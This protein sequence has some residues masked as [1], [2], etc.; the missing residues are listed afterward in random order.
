MKKSIVLILL[1]LVSTFT[2][3]AQSDELNEIV[4]KGVELHDNGQYEKAIETYK[5]ALKIDKKSIL[6]HY[7]MATTYFTL[8]KYDDAIK[9][10]DKV[11]KQKKKYIGSAYIIKGSAL[12][13][14][15]KSKAAIKAYRKGIKKDPTNHLLHYNLGLAA[16]NSKD[17]K[18]AEE[19]AIGAIQNKP[20]HGS[21]HIL[22]SYAM[23]AQNKR[24]QTILALYYF[25]MLES[26]SKR[27]VPAL[28]LLEAKLSSGVKKTGE[29]EI[30]VTFAPNDDDEFSAA[31][32]MLS[33]L[34][35]GK[36]LEKNEG[37]TEQELFIANS[38][39]FFK[40]M[41]EQNKKKKKGFWWAFYV[42]FFD[43]MVKAGH[44]EVFCNYISLSKKD[45][46]AREWIKANKEK[47]SAFSK[48]I[49]AYEF[50]IGK[51]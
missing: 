51:K 47:L 28:E 13:L 36:S 30:S 2:I 40:M 43:D 42:E 27:S 44:S 33:L 23:N 10:A 7:E 20:S 16:Y 32:L 11:I 35:A 49:N 31:E 26:D 38:E 6:V 21:S 9:H 1:L 3:T 8:K 22:L 19:G 37:K 48:W 17:Y 34:E 4:R 18:T 41:G 45:N 12:D 29:N 14:Q 15:G 5:T 39:S 25:L 24:V 50:N 46:K